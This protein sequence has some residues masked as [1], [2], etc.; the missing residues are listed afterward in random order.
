[1]AGRTH[2]RRFVLRNAVVL[3]VQSAL[4]LL[5]ALWSF[6]KAMREAVA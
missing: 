3:I 6:I 1:M 4:L 2:D 5:T